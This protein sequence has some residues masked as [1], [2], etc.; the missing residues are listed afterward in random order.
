MNN[1]IHIQHLSIQPTT[2]PIHRFGFPVLGVPFALLLRFASLRFAPPLATL[3]KGVRSRHA[4]PLCSQFV[5]LASQASQASSV[6]QRNG[7]KQ[8]QG[9]RLLRI[10]LDLAFSGKSQL[11]HLMLNRRLKAKAFQTNCYPGVAR[12]GSAG[13][14][15]CQETPNPPEGIKLS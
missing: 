4:S 7:N 9:L 1:S 15:H 13:V 14:R 10:H 3:T 11:K 12:N 5:L 2:Q 6:K 8:G